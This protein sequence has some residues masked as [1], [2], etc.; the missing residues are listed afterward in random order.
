VEECH[1]D[2]PH[3]LPPGEQII[4]PKA[5]T[6]NTSLD[7]AFA[8]TGTRDG[9][10]VR[11]LIG[12]EFKYTEPEFAPCTGF[13]AEGCTEQGRQACLHGKDR[14]NWCYLRHKE[15]IGIFKTDALDWLFG[16]PNPVDRAD[17][18]CALL[19]SLNQLY[20]GHSA[21]LKLKERFGYDEALFLV[22][23]DNRNL[24]LTTPERPSPEIRSDKAPMERYKDLLAEKHKN[25]FAA[26]AVQD[27]TAGYT[28]A[29][30]RKHPV[31]LTKIK[32]RYGW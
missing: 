28:A 8:L 10:P 25:T 2:V 3:A 22:V 12:V 30:T 32:S 24:A 5:D 26:L 21:V 19:G 17:G 4:F 29:I 9:K 6:L 14:G 20:R 13:T 18:A 23:Y 1:L 11:A 16:T 27:L 31:W 15:K 7:A